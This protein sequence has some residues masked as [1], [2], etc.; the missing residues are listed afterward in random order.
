[1]FLD[2]QD[3]TKCFCALQAATA[4]SVPEALPWLATNPFRV[5]ALSAD[6]GLILQVVAWMK[7]RPAQ[8]MY[9]RQIDL[10]GVDTKFIELHAGVLAELFDLVANRPMEEVPT[11]PT[12]FHAKFGFL[13]EPPRV[14]FRVLDPQFISHLCRINLM[15]NLTRKASP[16]CNCRSNVSS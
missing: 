8:K 4:A 11:A 16:L 12:D 10:P 7:T 2:V 13:R 9:T 1:M 5:I 15:S 3:N 14:R 6:W